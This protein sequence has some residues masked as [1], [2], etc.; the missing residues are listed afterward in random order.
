MRQTK[1]CAHT[2]LLTHSEIQVVVRCLWCSPP[3]VFIDFF[4]VSAVLV[5]D[6]VHAFHQDGKTQRPFSL[7]DV[8]RRKVPGSKANF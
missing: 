5:R 4:V 8:P 7:R 3:A 2:R 1:V 6:D